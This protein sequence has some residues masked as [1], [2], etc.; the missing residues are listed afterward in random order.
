MSGPWYDPDIWL[1]ERPEIEADTDRLYE[2][3]PYLSD[4]LIVPIIKKEATVMNQ[5]IL[6]GR[7]R[8][9]FSYQQDMAAT[10]MVTF[11]P[12]TINAHMKELQPEITQISLD[13]NHP[14][15]CYGSA[16]IEI[17]F[18]ERS[19]CS[20]RRELVSLYGVAENSRAQ[21]RSFTISYETQWDEDDIRHYEDHYYDSVIISGLGH[22]P[23]IRS[24]TL[25]LLL[26]R[27]QRAIGTSIATLRFGHTI[28]HE[29]MRNS[30]DP[31]P[32]EGAFYRAA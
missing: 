7:S 28:D 14:F 29:V 16:R 11:F 4:H 27:S 24:T 3:D 21:L 15:N 6:T 13:N 19:A 31:Y 32:A 22:L 30:S 12:G 10:L 23:A 9:V 2:A 26:H 20:R 17:L 25:K 18:Y 1:R 8:L 5:P